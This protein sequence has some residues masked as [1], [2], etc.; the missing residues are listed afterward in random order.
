MNKIAELS[1]SYD[2]T[3]V[4]AWFEEEMWSKI[5]KRLAYSIKGDYL[6]LPGFHNSLDD[7]KSFLI[8]L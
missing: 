1:L 7:F 2:S 3:D 6:S 5:G 8:T 4:W